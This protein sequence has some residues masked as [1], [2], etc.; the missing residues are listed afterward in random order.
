MIP[1]KRVSSDS[2]QYQPGYVGAVPDRT[3]HDGMDGVVWAMEYLT[4]I[5]SSKVYDVAIETPLQLAPKLSERLGAQ[6]WLKRED[7]QPVIVFLRLFSFLYP[8]CKIFFYLFV[9]FGFDHFFDFRQNLI[10]PFSFS[11][12]THLFLVLSWKRGIFIFLLLFQL[13]WACKFLGLFV[14]LISLNG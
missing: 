3:I 7:L 4:N 13:S 6:V 12:I 10:V 5:L 11:P 8:N 9:D 1:L 14:S 2:L